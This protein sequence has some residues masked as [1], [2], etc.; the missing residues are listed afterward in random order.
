MLS[1]TVHLWRWQENSGSDRSFLRVNRGRSV[2]MPG[3]SL[4]PLTPTACSIESEGGFLP[5]CLTRERHETVLDMRTT[6]RIDDAILRDAKA[7]AARVGR[8]LNEFIEDAV[9]VALLAETESMA[10][11]PIP[12]FRE[13]RGLL[14]GVSLDNGSA[15]LDVMEQRDRIR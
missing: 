12:F 6:I 14:P 9:R 10:P 2:P 13:G 3:V 7:R 1:D 8:S 11:P 15:L 5:D 4:Y